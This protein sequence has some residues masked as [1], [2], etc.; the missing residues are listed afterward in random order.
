MPSFD[1]LTISNPGGGYTLVATGTGLAAGTSPPFNVTTDQL[2]VTTPPPD[3]LAAGDAFQ[4]GRFGR[5]PQW[6][7]GTPRSNG[8]VTLVLGNP[9][10][11]V[12]VG[13]GGTLNVTAVDG[14]ATFGPLTLDEFGPNGH[15]DI[16]VESSSIPDTYA[17]INVTPDPATQLVVTSPLVPLTEGQ[18]FDFNISAEDS[19]GNVDPTFDGAVTLALGNNSGGA[20]LGGDTHR[21]S[22]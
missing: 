10:G 16:E 17:Q 1:D 5:G 15:Y 4:H 14:V 12:A 22:G 9:Y 6:R 11:G 19:Y 20:T 3:S 8:N 18:S 2:V 21:A 13:L 7:R